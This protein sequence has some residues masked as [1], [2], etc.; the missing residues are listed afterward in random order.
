M[1]SKGYVKY[2]CIVI[3]III[4]LLAGIFMTYKFGNRNA[5][6]QENSVETNNGYP[7]Y[8]ILTD[9][10]VFFVAENDSEM[11]SEKELVKLNLENCAFVSDD[12]STGD[13]VR[14]NFMT[15]ADLS[16]CIADVD[17]I[18]KIEAGDVSNIDEEV[19]EWLNEKGYK[20]Y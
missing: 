10:D 13:R 20:I 18:E 11:L 16:P 2:V 3:G 5:D 14:I 1:N 8:I 4:V 9:S 19:I 6:I 17:F 15:I 12:F 7:G